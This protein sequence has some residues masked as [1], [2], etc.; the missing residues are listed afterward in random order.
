MRGGR[1]GHSTWVPRALEISASQ[2]GCDRFLRCPPRFCHPQLGGSTSPDT[3]LRVAS[4]Q[5]RTPLT[6]SPCLISAPHRI[7]GVTVSLV[8]PRPPSQGSSN[9]PA[10][11]GP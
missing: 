7:L 3:V 5:P 6:L 11:T 2:P 1:A 10:P 9:P 8:R 4:P